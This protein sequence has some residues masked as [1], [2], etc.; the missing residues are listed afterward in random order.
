MSAKIEEKLSLDE[1]SLKELLTVV[2]SSDVLEVF[3]NHLD[4]NL[5]VFTFKDSNKPL[6]KINIYELS[7]NKFVAW[8]N[9]MEYNIVSGNTCD[10]K[11]E[12]FAIRFED[13]FETSDEYYHVITDNGCKAVIDACYWVHQEFMKEK[14]SA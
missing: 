11:H 4:S 5:L 9:S 6:E 10:S 2:Y 12:A 8:A 14:K 7:Y 3:D 1:K 13:D